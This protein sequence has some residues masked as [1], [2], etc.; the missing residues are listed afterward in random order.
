[1]LKYNI[2]IK[3]TKNR[4]L[5]QSPKIQKHVIILDTLVITVHNKYG[6]RRG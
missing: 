4:K 2:M 6:W 1:M 3:I 5:K